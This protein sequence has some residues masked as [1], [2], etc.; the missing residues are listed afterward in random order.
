[1]AHA[2]G[3]WVAL[4][5][6]CCPRAM[7]ARP[8]HLPQTQFCEFPALTCG[9]QWACPLPQCGPWPRL[10]SPFGAAAVCCRPLRACCRLCGDELSR[11]VVPVWGPV[12]VQ[13]PW[14]AVTAR[15][16]DRL[17]SLPVTV[18]ASPT[19]PVT[20]FG[21][22]L[23][24]ERLAK[25][26]QGAACRRC[27]GRAPKPPLGA[28]ASLAGCSALAPCR[29]SRRIAQHTLFAFI[30]VIFVHHVSSHMS[31]DELM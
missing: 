15:T 14:A 13:P 20:S 12:Q 16:G 23:P 10:P 8:S 24:C 27:L 9:S 22:Q 3:W 26:H 28:V 30:Q 2:P 1:M 18:E 31:L 6:L 4:L 19:S 5:S 29:V 25:T 21:L 17:S 11:L 7:T